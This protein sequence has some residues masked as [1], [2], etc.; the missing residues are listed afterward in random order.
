MIHV[1]D[2]DSRMRAEAAHLIL[3]MGHHAEVY[4]DFGELQRHP[5]QHGIIIARE[6]APELSVTGILDML[7]RA[8]IALPLIVAS[9][10]GGLRQAVDAIAAGAFD[11]LQLPF[12]K[13]SLDAVLRRVA[14]AAEEHG[15]IRRR[16]IE[17]RAL[18][19]SLSTR[20]REVLDL[21]V[22]GGSNKHIARTLQISPRTVEIHR[23]NMMQKL[24]VGHVAGVVRLY[25]E[26]RLQRDGAA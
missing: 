7:D 2:G 1:V 9:L 21:L 17:A 6:E 26:A 24:G 3:T 5:P 22:G 25:L 19:G 12:D 13:L 8:G 23:S 14:D 18:I 4:T 15:L 11:F 10:G 20:E 16:M